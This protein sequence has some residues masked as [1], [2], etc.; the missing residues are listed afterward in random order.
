[1]TGIPKIGYPKVV[2]ELDDL[3]IKLEIRLADLAFIKYVRICDQY[4]FS[5]QLVKEIIIRVKGSP[6]ILRD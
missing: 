4:F 5:L 3:V 2:S 6:V 1:M